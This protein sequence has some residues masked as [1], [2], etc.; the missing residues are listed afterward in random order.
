M[1]RSEFFAHAADS[2][3]DQLDAQSVTEQINAALQEAGGLDDSN[4]AAVEAARARLIATDE[5]W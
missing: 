3:L 2:Y 5:Q 1:S 4:Q